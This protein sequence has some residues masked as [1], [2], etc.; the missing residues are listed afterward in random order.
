MPDFNLMGSLMRDLHQEFVRIYYLMLP[1]FFCLSV[2]VTWMRSSGSGLDFV[3]VLKRALISTLLLVA[4]PE[5]SQAI[6]FIADGIAE[7]IDNLNSLDMAI[8]MAEEKSQ[9]YSGSVASLLLQFNDLIVAVLS[10]LSFLIL[11]IAR[12]I[13]IAMYHFFWL[14]YMVSA[15]LLLLFNLFPSTGNITANLFRGMIEVACWK[16]VWAILGAMLVSLSFG[17]AYRAEGNYLTIIVMNFV[18]AIAMLATPLLVKSIASQG[19]HA[20]SSSL[21]QTAV[22]AMAAVPTKGLSIAARGKA[23]MDGVGHYAKSKVSN[24]KFEKKKRADVYRS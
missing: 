15:P 12:Y 19:A 22:N 9:S 10:F 7:K 8:R 13:T 23:S 1:V 20:M 18:I 14:F 24:Y 6:I 4:L 17:D 5:I 2:V 3:D 21:G 11:Y 16:I